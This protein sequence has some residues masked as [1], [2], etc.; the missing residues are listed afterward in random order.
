MLHHGIINTITVFT[1]HSDRDQ[2]SNQI[3]KE[4]I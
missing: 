4:F 2:K 3:K 1:L